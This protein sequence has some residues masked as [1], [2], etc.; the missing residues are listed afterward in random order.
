MS[1]SRNMEVESSRQVWHLNGWT[2][3]HTTRRRL[4]LPELLSEP[5]KSFKYYFFNVARIIWAELLLK[6][7]ADL[8]RLVYQGRD[9]LEPHLSEVEVPE[10]LQLR[11]CQA[12]VP[13]PL[14][15]AKPQVQKRGKSLVYDPDLIPGPDVHCEPRLWVIQ[16]RLC[17][18]QALLHPAALGC[19]VI[20]I[21]KGKKT[22]KI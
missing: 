12:Q 10:T 16:L 15:N 3:G 11:N 14:S 4:S 20:N 1:Q 13:I 5:K 18:T 2:N 8:N 9:T 22:I 17:L 19:L 6:N 7:A 21:P